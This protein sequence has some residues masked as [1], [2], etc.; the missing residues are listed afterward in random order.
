MAV[1]G[2][3][4]AGGPSLAP[5]GAGGARPPATGLALIEAWLAPLDGR[6][7][8]DVGCGGGALAQALTARG[9]RVIGIDP[10]SEA[11]AAARRAAPGAVFEVAVA[12]AL[13]FAAESVDAAVFVNSLHHVPVAAMGVA[14]AEALRVSRGPVVVIEPLAEGP[15]FEALRPVEDETAVR[16]AA[17]AAIAALLASGGAVL[18]GGGDYDEVRRFAGVDAFLDKVVSVDPARADAA[19]RLRPQVEALMRRWGRPEAAGLRLDQPHR[20]HLLRRIS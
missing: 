2:E 8:L 14:L 12:Q 6:A 16:Q 7:V 20:V 9:A 13:P 5:F 11:V 17:Q 10:S 3:R 18:A 1:T 19:R 4:D 15:F